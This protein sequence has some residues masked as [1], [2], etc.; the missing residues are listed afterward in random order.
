[1]NNLSWAVMGVYYKNNLFAI[2]LF[3]LAKNVNTENWILKCSS[4]YF[5]TY[6]EVQAL[7]SEI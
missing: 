6:I 2:T 3:E 1:M 4:N 5:K 7:T